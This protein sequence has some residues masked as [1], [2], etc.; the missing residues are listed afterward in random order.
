MTDSKYTVIIPHY[1]SPELLK[2]CL[3]S[4]P[5]R[6]DIQVIVVDDCSNPDVVDFEDLPGQNRLY[7]EVYKTS[8]GGS[9]GR[10]RN[11]G[12]RHAKGKWLLFADADDFF[13]P[14][15][16]D[17]FDSY[18]ESEHDI[19]YFQYT[20][21]DSNTLEPNDRHMVYGRYFDA[22]FSNPNKYTSDHLR[23]RHDIPWGKMI[24]RSIVEENGIEFGETRYCND[25]LFSTKTAIAAQRVQIESRPTYCVTSDNKS[26]THQQSSEAL[27]IRLDVLLA[28]NQLLRSHG[29][30]K[31]QPSILFYYREALGFGI[32][33]FLS[34]LRLAYDHRTPLTMIY[35][36]SRLY[37]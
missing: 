19:I 14:G 27:L 26:L 35:I 20:S 3:G 30:G 23:Y 33:T 32:Q 18:Y 36:Y 10:A 25:T 11:V 1:N 31:H 2:R 22:Y 5:E 16:W 12:L 9:A 15:A 17:V 7:T 4:I 13:L 29:L 28:K 6:N 21:V 8:Q 24:R 37:K 34:A